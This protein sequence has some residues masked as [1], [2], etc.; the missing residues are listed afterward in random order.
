MKLLEETNEMLASD[1]SFT[2]TGL[3]IGIIP[4]RMLISKGFVVEQFPFYVNDFICLH[5][6]VIV[7]GNPLFVLIPGLDGTR[8]CRVFATFLP[9]VRNKVC[10]ADIWVFVEVR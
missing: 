10:N 1:D 4:R 7:K 5:L 2:R 6:R 3:I 9:W 8:M